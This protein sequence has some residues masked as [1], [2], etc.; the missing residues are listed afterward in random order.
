M[1]NGI[2]NSILHLSETVFPWWSSLQL[3]ERIGTVGEPETF[4]TVNGRFVVAD[5]DPLDLWKVEL[6]ASGNGTV[7]M[8]SFDGWYVGRETLVD[9]LTYFTAHIL[10]GGTS[11]VLA[12]NAVPEYVLARTEQTNMPVPVNYDPATRTV[13]IPVGL[14]EPVAVMYRVRLVCVCT[15]LPSTETS[16]QTGNQA[17]EITFEEQGDL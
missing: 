12:R 16:V 5:T 15:K 1:A 3:S 13:T 8:P 7:F 11:V 2:P 14:P 17:W 4:R 9:C 10:P 6:S